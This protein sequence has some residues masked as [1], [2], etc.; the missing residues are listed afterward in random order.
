MKQFVYLIVLLIITSCANNSFKN[1]EAPEISEDNFFTE[2][3]ASF[4]TLEDA[5]V[6]LVSEKLQDYL[7]KQILVNQ[8]PEFIAK[9]DTPVLFTTKKAKEIRQVKFIG[10][11]EILSD[12]ITKIITQVHFGNTQ[13][14]TIISYITTSETLID[15]VRFK[16]SKATFERMKSSKKT[17]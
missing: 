10:Q 1:M 17:D 16:T 4:A 5:Y 6:V 12:S 13:T 9:E 8:H 14:D 7:D 3:E 15:G 11:P 2:D